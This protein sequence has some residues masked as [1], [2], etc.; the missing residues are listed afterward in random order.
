MTNTAQKITARRVQS[1]H[2]MAAL[3]RAFGNAFLTAENTIYNVASKMSPDYNGGSW[4][5]YRLDNGGFFMA[6]EIENLAWENVDNYGRG[7][8]TGE[9]YGLAVCLYAYSQLSGYYHN[10]AQQGRG[11]E[12][13]AG[14]QLLAM[15]ERFASHYH[16]VR[17]FALD[18]SHAGEI[19]ALLD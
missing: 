9:A 11:P 14:R 5:F 19:F 12:S 1:N 18:H 4:E 3:P 7:F 10:Q 6:P 17:A 2:R 8:M 15:S 16:A 13:P